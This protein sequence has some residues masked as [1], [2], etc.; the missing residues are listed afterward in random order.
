MKAYFVAFDSKLTPAQLAAKRRRLTA[1]LR[2]KGIELQT[3]QIGEGKSIIQRLAA[4]ARG[5][6]VIVLDDEHSDPNKSPWVQQLVKQSEDLT[7]LR[8][9]QLIYVT[10]QT[11]AAG[12]THATNHPILRSYVWGDAKGL[13]VKTAAM[14]AMEVNRQLQAQ[15]AATSSSFPESDDG[16]IVGAST[17]FREA[18]EELGRLMRLPYCMVSGEAG[19]GKM[20]LIRSLWRPLSPDARL[21]VVPC[22]SFF[23]D[24]YVNGNR[25]RF[26]GGRE[27]VDQLVPYLEEADEGLLV[28]HHVERLPTALQEELVARL[29]VAGS[30]GFK[31]PVVGVDRNNLVEHDIRIVAT[32]I[33]SPA[34]LRDRGL[35]PELAVKFAK[36]H[37][38][39][40]S[41][42]Q[43]G[44]DDV[45]LVC[46]DL[47]GRIVHRHAGDDANWQRLVPAFDP[48]AMQLLRRAR[49]PDNVSDL[50][51]W[52]EYAWRHC[53]GGTIQRGHLP[54]DIVVSRTQPAGTLDQ[55]V[56]EAQ[57][58]A[59]QNALDQ[60]GN[61]MA[62]A[63]TLLGRNKAALYRLMGTLGMTERPQDQ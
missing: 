10:Q 36:R 17:C 60:T 5:A 58:S 41:L 9:P 57:R 32:S 23:K 31:N 56:D 3:L 11:T 27:A 1:L 49:C 63:A 39:V 43:R 21:V 35:V 24:Y 8:R 62:Q 45:E 6:P 44:H 15:V 25:R 16:G 61:D 26:G 18:I 42:A 54:P 51:R 19:V 46:R 30:A 38:R 2:E 29:L 52:M 12:T 59:I 20:F 14:L 50:L 48:A 22:G 37:V 7:P 55:V 53:H 13:W 33:R 40:P 28:L 47:L 34:E 4:D